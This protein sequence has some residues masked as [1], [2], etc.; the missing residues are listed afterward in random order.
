M[1]T[2]WKVAVVESWQSLHKIFLK[3]P[4]Y[5]RGIGVAATS[6]SNASQFIGWNRQVRSVLLTP[7]SQH[8]TSFWQNDHL[9]LH[10]EPTCW[11]GEETTPEH[12]VIAGCV[13]E[14]WARGDV[15]SHP[16]CVQ[17]LHAHLR[18]I[19][20]SDCS[21]LRNMIWRDIMVD[22][23]KYSMIKFAGSL[24]DIKNWTLAG[25]EENKWFSIYSSDEEVILPGSLSL[26]YPSGTCGRQILAS[27]DH[28]CCNAHT[29]LYLPPWWIY[30]WV[31]NMQMK[32]SFDEMHYINISKSH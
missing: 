31:L 29:S 7:G 12:V 27:R 5:A 19:M 20:I 15:C 9:H 8:R 16:R 22:R 32:K 4:R 23:F 11:A 26:R 21:M 30:V 13:D 24:I 18:R 3:R 14:V 17:V 10:R 2:M 25:C 28:S 6:L 1:P